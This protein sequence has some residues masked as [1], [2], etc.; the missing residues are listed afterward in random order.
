[1]RTI[2]MRFAM[3]GLAVA[4]VGCDRGERPRRGF[5]H[6]NGPRDA[7]ARRRALRGRRSGLRLAA[8][9]LLLA[10][11]EFRGRATARR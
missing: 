11:A 8:R 7:G 5:Y 3:L 2:A 4:T 1:M 9:V 10:I 6:R